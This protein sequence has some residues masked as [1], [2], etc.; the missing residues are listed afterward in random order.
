MI[1]SLLKD[2]QYKKIPFRLILFC[3]ALNLIGIAVI[4]SARASLQKTQIVGMALGLA[5]MIVVALVDYSLYMYLHWLVYAGNLVLLL[6]VKYSPLGDDGLGATRWLSIGGFRFQPSEVSKLCIILFFAWFF[7]KYQEKINRFGMILVSGILIFVPWIL[8]NRQPDLSTSIVTALIF[9]AMFFLSGISYK[10]IGGVLAVVIPAGAVFLALIMQ[11]D[12]EILQDYQLN[13][14]MAW[15]QPTNPKYISDAYQQQNSIMAI[16]SGQLWGKGL[17]TESVYSVKNGNY[18]PEPQTDFIF[19]VAGEE[20]GFVGAAA[21]LVLLL[22][23]VLECIMIGRKARNLQGRLICGGVA[24]MIG[25]QA[26]V[27]LCV[28]TGLMPNTGLTLP[29][30]SYGLTSLVS[31]YIAIGF[32]VNV[33][34]QP[35][36]YRRRDGLL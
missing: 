30:V 21:I 6:L 19:S 2:Y 36:K 23:I 8:I 16:G 29:F 3:V 13:R 14:I 25:F 12:Q 20:L 27:N 1:F 24:A 10:I 9:L 7:G 34:I 4:G 11:P 26:F 15:L 35:N 5:A 17:N 33:A 28:V 32:V 22:L 18:L 31:L